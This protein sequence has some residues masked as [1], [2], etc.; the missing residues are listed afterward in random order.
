MTPRLAM[1]HAQEAMDKDQNNFYLCKSI[2]LP[3]SAITPNFDKIEQVKL[4]L[5]YT[6]FEEYQAQK[7]RFA[8]LYQDLK[9]SQLAALASAWN[10]GQ[11]TFAKTS[12]K[13][14]T[15][16]KEKPQL[17]A[18]YRQLVKQHQKL[19][20]KLKKLLKTKYKTIQTSKVTEEI[21]SF[22]KES[23]RLFVALESIVVSKSAL[24]TEVDTPE[25][26]N[27][28]WR[29]QEKAMKESWRNLKKKAGLARW[30][31]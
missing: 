27:K 11:Q 30:N 28:N 31:S 21:N 20:E 4:G 3:W 18:S 26:Q 19:K 16:K 6:N 17:Q 23:D 22:D 1:H 5:E 8:K 25:Q 29:D 15:L 13:L 9:R 10:L 14:A 12:A 2:F 7:E 24:E